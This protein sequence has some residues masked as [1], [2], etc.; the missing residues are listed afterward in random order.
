MC[1][2]LKFGKFFAF[3]AFSDDL[4]VEDGFCMDA[5]FVGESLYPTIS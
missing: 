2:D 3:I 5:C 1:L 4:T